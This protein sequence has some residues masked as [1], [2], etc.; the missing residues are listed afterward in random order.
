MGNVKNRLYISRKYVKQKVY[1][2]ARHAFV[3]GKQAIG[4]AAVAQTGHAQRQRSLTYI[5]LEL[6]GDLID[7]ADKIILGGTTNSNVFI[8]ILILI[9]KNI[10]SAM[11]NGKRR[12]I[13]SRIKDA[14]GDFISD[15]N[16]MFI[17]GYV[18]ISKDHGLWNLSYTKRYKHLVIL[19]DLG[20][21][22]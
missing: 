6:N 9:F 19:S 13:L 18:D 20:G 16:G 1:D 14:A 5:D 21:A 8:Q 10:L 7:D 12:P 11:V 15:V 2:W 17:D 4:I 22:N 3:S